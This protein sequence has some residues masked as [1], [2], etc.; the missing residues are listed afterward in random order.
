L[1][2]LPFGDAEP[3]ICQRAQF[4][5]RLEEVRVEDLGARLRRKDELTP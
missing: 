4:G 1:S 5:D 2:P 3:L